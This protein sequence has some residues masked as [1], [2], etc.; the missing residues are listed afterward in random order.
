VKNSKIINYLPATVVFG[1][2][3]PVC[4]KQ[5][6]LCKPFPVRLIHIISCPMSSDVTEEASRN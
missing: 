5:T 2:I 4:V 6:L 1:G 3:G